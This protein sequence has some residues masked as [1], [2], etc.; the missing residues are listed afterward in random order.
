MMHARP[1]GRHR[2]M[3]NGGPH[4]GDPSPSVP[5]LSLRPD[6]ALPGA[7][8]GNTL[9]SSFKPISPNTRDEDR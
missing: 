8:I 3:M 1:T 9:G 7:V 2:D 6:S 5:V 4:G